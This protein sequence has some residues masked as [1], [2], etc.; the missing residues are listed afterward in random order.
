M[1]RGKTLNTD[2]LFDNLTRSMQVDQA[3]VNF[4]FVAV[5]GLGALT[6]RL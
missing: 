2:D 4:E 3:L 5:P 1:R 6:T